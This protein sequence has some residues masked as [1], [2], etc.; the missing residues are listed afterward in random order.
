M[1]SLEAAFK[2]KQQK[3]IAIMKGIPCFNFLDNNRINLII[4]SIAIR[5]KK[6]P[7]I[8][9]HQGDCTSYFYILTEGEIKIKK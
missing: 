1:M 8:I 9:Y 4:Q 2:E 6:K 3:T 5:K 7:F